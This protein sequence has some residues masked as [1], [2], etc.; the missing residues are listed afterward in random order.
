[1]ASRRHNGRASRKDATR[2][3]RDACLVVATVRERSSVVAAI[4]RASELEGSIE[5]MNP[6]RPQQSRQ[7]F[8]RVVGALI[9]AIR[10]ASAIFLNDVNHTGGDR[11]RRSAER[12]PRD[13]GNAP[14]SR[15]FAVWNDRR[16]IRHCDCDGWLRPIPRCPP[17][18]PSAP[19]ACARLFILRL[20]AIALAA[21][22]V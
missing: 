1:M 5:D 17:R 4:R 18:P 11:G 15:Y 10:R 7:P 16:H 8:V 20:H 2:G 12:A 6:R 13:G 21:S 14:H 22:R 3:D 9:S 19:R